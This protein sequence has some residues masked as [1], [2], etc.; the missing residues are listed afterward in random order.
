MKPK[1]ILWQ[2]PLR[3]C[4]T[5][6]NNGDAVSVIMFTADGDY[7]LESVVERHATAGVDGSPVTLDVVKIAGA[8]VAVASGTTMLSSTFSMKSTINTNVRKDHQEGGLAANPSSRRL[9]K[10]NSLGLKFG[11][12]L[13]TLAGVSI[14]LVLQPITKPP[15]W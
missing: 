13:T 8:G 11:G 10:G 5:F 2:A 12:V 15:N 14:T 7:E 1:A 9:A 4:H 3:L 6:T